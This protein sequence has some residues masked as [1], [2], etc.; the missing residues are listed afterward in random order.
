MSPYRLQVM[1]KGIL[2]AIIVYNAFLPVQFLLLP[3]TAP[4]A[5]ALHLGLITPAIL[6]VG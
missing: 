6:L 4:L 2:R 1:E 3:R 5:L